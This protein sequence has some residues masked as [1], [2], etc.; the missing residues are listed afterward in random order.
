MRQKKP[1]FWEEKN[2]ISFLLLPLSQ[3]TFTLNLRK[4]FI[5]KKKFRIK[6]ICVG[7]IYVGGTGKTSL[8]IKINKILKNKFGTVFI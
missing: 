7:N 4:I 8:C 2:F 6:T 1:F 3:I 5:K